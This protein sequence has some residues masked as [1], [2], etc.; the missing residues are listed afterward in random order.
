MGLKAKFSKAVERGGKNLVLA[1]A[2][3]LCSGGLSSAI[4]STQV[5]PVFHLSF[6]ALAHE[7]SNTTV[8]VESASLLG[9]ELQA[10]RWRITKGQHHRLLLV[11][12][13]LLVALVVSYLVLQCFKILASGSAKPWRTRRLAGEGDP[14][15]DG[16]N[17]SA[18]FM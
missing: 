10:F 13:A 17:V 16:C 7:P 2:F 5:S 14:T 6:P 9:G 11:T 15:E 12:S 4:E 18:C 8:H 3:V 1:L